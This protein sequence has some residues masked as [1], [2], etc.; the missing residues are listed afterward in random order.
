[1]T[2]KSNITSVESFLIDSLEQCN[3]EMHDKKYTGGVD[4]VWLEG[5]LDT[6]RTVGQ[7]RSVCRS[8]MAA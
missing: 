6:R 2:E 5:P 4:D 8:W 3:M 1:M 7:Q